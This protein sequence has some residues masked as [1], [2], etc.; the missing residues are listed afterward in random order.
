[1]DRDELEE[2]VRR[3][4]GEGGFRRGAGGE[5]GYVPFQPEPEDSLALRRRQEAAAARRVDNLPGEQEQ[6]PH[7]PDED[8]EEVVVAAP[9]ASSPETPPPPAAPSVEP[10]PD[11]EYDYPPPEAYDDAPYGRP[12]DAYAYPY[13]TDERRPGGGA[14]PIIGFVVLCVLA[15]GVGAVLAGLLGGD[16]PAGQA[17]PSASAEASA[18]ASDEASTEPSAEASASAGAATPQPS[19]GPVAFPDGALMTIQPCDTRDFLPGAV[20]NP[21]AAACEVDGS[22][23]S[24]GSVWAVIVFS[25]AVGTDTLQVQLRSN[26]E[27]VVEPQEAVLSSNVN[28]PGTCSGLVY[29]AAYQG[30]EPGDYELVLNR[31]GEFADAATFVVEG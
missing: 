9:L 24:D 21:D 15:L 5:A 7:W 22:S 30:L 6:Q 23:V 3:R 10:E 17:S 31:N 12:E 11:P 1:M 16:D 2:R 29:G 20:G 4:P 28:C 14:L 26:G 25:D 13:Y 19:D 8:R 27:Q 18:E